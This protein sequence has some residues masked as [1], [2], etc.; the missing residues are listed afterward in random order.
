[1]PIDPVKPAALRWK[2]KP[3][4]FRFKTS[5]ELKPTERIVGQDRAVGAS[6]WAWRFPARATTCS[7]PVFPGAAARQR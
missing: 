2:C 5:E 3:S 6:G 7:S 1:M 4:R